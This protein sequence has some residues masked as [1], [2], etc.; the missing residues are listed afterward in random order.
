MMNY[1]SRGGISGGRDWREAQ[2]MDSDKSSRIQGI[3]GELQSMQSHLRKVQEELQNQKQRNSDLALKLDILEKERNSQQQQLKDLRDSKRKALESLSMEKDA[4]IVAREDLVAQLRV[5]KKRLQETEYE[6]IKAEEDATSLRA[7]LEMLHHRDEHGRITPSLSF[8]PE[9]FRAMEQEMASLKSEMQDVLQQL[10]KEQQMLSAEQRRVAE[11]TAEREQLKDALSEACPKP[12]QSYMIPNFGQ[13]AVGSSP[14]HLKEKGKY[15]QQLRE[16][17]SMVERLESG[18][19]TLLA[20]IDVQSLE[21]ERLFT[22]NSS[23]VAGLNE[24]K[25]AAAQ[26]ENHVHVAL[27]E[28]ARL[29]G[30]LNELRTRQAQSVDL[31][32]LDNYSYNLE[33]NPGNGNME[34]AILSVKDENLKLKV[35]LAQEQGQAEALKA[36]VFQLTADLNHTILNLNSLSKLYKPVLSSIEN[37]LLQLKQGSEI[38]DATF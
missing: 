32:K 35:E 12:Q 13:N 30:M 21:I 14:D 9:Q 38:S 17:A 27:E 20:E 33:N 28:N 7:E 2:T 23:L 3:E 10:Q 11:L 24:V 15:E 16:L 29:R 18:R 25:E 26:S 6:Q 34:T 8:T 22:E 37:R 5:L 19:Q 31:Q 4:A 36:Q 1:P